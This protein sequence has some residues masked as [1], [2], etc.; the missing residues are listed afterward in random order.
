MDDVSRGRAPL[1]E[2]K[3]VVMELAQGARSQRLGPG[4][5]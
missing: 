5:L 1:E 2:R 4:D 3:P